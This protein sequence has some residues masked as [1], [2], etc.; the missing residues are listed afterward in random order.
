MAGV[1]AE[2]ERGRGAIR[3]AQHVGAKDEEAMR[4][5]R[6]SAAHEGSP[7]VHRRVSGRANSRGH[8]PVFDV[9]AAGEGVADDHDV[10]SGLVEPAPCFVRDGDVSQKA[11]VFERKGGHDVDALFEGGWHDGSQQRP[12][13]QSIVQTIQVPLPALSSPSVGFL[14]RSLIVHV[15]VSLVHATMDGAW[16]L[17]ACQLPLFPA[18]EGQCPFT[19]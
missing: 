4:V 17:A 15:A 16:C 13:L 11:P 9:C 2:R 12:D 8:P 18:N 1:W 19:L 6:L 10:V 7:P 3:R 5:K 14:Y